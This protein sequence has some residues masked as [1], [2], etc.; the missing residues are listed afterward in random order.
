[1]GG[2]VRVYLA[3][4][5]YG[6]T[7]SE[8]MDWRSEARA[9]LIGHECVDPMVRDCRGREEECFE[10]VVLRDKADIDS[11]HAMLV[12]FNRPSVGTAME[13]LY[14]WEHGCSVFVVNRSGA[15]LSP[16][17]RFHSYAIHESLSA[18]VRAIKELV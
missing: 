9:L 3:G 18:A 5:I 8:A 16:W 17:L 11:C 15:S 7:D 13:V 4:P 10:D 1:M 6:C 12:M 2:P 14:A